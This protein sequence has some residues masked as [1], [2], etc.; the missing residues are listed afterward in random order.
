MVAPKG[1]GATLRWRFQRGE[2]IPALIAV[3]RESSR[4]DAASLMLGWANAIGCA[5]AALL[6]TTFAAEAESDLFGEQ[7]V[8]CGGMLGLIRSAFD[9]LVDAGY[10]PEVAY[11]ECCHELKQVADLVY[12][13]GLLGMTQAISNTA[14]FGAYEAAGVIADDATRDRLR[15]ILADVRSGAF[16]QRM[17]ADHACGAAKIES[18]RRDL[19]DDQIEQASATVRSYMPFLQQGDTSDSQ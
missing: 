15:A 19:A 10:P 17:M 18:H 16:A 13:R 3:H 5:R 6:R 14:E 12:E 4:G 2:G 9:V 1:P 7:A 8:L 11:I